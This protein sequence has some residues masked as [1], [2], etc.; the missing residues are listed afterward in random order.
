MFEGSL[1]IFDVRETLNRVSQ[2]KYGGMA[3]KSTALQIFYRERLLQIIAVITSAISLREPDLALS[4]KDKLKVY[5]G[6]LFR[7]YCVN[8]FANDCM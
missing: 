4:I 3:F 7:S 5:E 2:R 8:K 6:I 1:S